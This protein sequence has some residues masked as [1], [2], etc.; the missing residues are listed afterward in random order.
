[1]SIESANAAIDRM[2]AD[3]AFATQVK[4]AGSPESSLSVLAAEGFEVTP[5]EMRD[6]MIDRYGDQLSQE[7]L[8]T[9]VGG[10]LG[11]GDTAILV[12][13][14]ITGAGLIGLGAAAAAIV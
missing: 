13:G 11:P 6:A 14:S 8:D 12:A 9:L 2:E 1:M 5:Q 7:Q 3:E 4:D 10:E